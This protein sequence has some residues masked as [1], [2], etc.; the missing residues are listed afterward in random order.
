M[1]SSNNKKVTNFDLSSL[2]TYRT[3]LMGIATLMII[4]CHA[5]ASGVLMPS[6]LAKILD[7]GN[8]G[9]DIFLFLSG[10]GCYYTL[11]KSVRTVSYYK[12]RT[13]R[14]LIPY[15]T[16]SLPFAIF[17]WAIGQ[18][19][20]L[21]CIYTITTLE[22]WLYHKGA[23]FVALMIPLY[24]ISPL[25]YRA[26]NL[27]KVSWM[28]SIIIILILMV[29]SL[30][31][32]YNEANDSIVNNIQAAFSRVPSFILGM[33]IAPYCKDRKKINV[34]FAVALMLLFIILSAFHIK[35]TSTWWCII[36]IL[37]MILTK[38]CSLAK[39][40]KSAFSI[41][42]I[43]GTISLESY[44]LNIYINSLLRFLIP[45][46]IHSSIFLGRYLEYG[47]VVVFGIVLAL[48]INNLTN[49]ILY[50]NNNR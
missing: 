5:P 26:M 31:P 47:I 44:L 33:T 20:I 17:Y 50:A 14:L 23:W 2:S 39:N 32:L 45:N 15:L 13:Y 36:P 48:L 46:Y 34:L 40:N 7:L 35:G 37:I 6:V 42:T 16:I 9:V 10:L 29:F 49:K 43:L 22:F 19:S 24:F 21:D 3:Q 12:K 30:F 8:L 1:I 11:S 41:L 27:G 25:L 28:Y 18:N 38:C 4:V